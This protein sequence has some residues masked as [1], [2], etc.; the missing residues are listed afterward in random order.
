MVLSPSLFDPQQLFG[1]ESAARSPAI[2]ARILFR[3]S[4]DGLGEDP[5]RAVHGQL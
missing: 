3:F 1:P 5:A 2:L 4:L